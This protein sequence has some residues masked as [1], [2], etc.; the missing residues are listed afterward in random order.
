MRLSLNWNKS[1]EEISAETLKRKRTALFMANEAKRLMNPYVPAKNLVLA[2]NV[3]V[4]NEGDGAVV[5]YMSPH[6]HYQ[7]VGKLMVSSRTGNPWARHGESK[8]YAVP[9]RKLKQ[10]R[11]RH[12]LATSE[13]DKAM[14]TAH[15]E[16]LTKAVQGYVRKG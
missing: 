2:K 8:V 7:Y 9:E 1:F 5:H 13:W 3:R 10:G 11:L 12:T 16:D 15:K 6:A 4:Y 14:M